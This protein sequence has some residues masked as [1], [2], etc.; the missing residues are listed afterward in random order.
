[1]DW[2]AT[3]LLAGATDVGGRRDLLDY[4]RSLAA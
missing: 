1:M 3:G 4:L 2:E